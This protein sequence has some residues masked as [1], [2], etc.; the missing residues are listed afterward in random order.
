[1]FM[2]L[3]PV[4]YRWINRGVDDNHDRVHCGLVAQEVETSAVKHGLSANEFATICKDR[5]DVPTTDG[6][7]TVY[8]LAYSELHGLE[9]HMIQKNARS[10][11]TVNIDL[12]NIKNGITDI[13]MDL[14]NKISGLQADLNQERAERS[15]LEA[16]V[17]MLQ[18]RLAQ[19]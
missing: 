11:A 17:D 18:N 13:R 19:A 2:D 15:R 1:M 7:T 4:N 14:L 10:I 12:I 16:V 3:K 9:I 6:R 5:L 8:G